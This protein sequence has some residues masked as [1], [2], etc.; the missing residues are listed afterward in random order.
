MARIAI[1]GTGAWGTALANVLLSNKH[2]VAMWGVDQTQIND[3]KKQVNTQYYGNTKLVS[4][5]K[6]VTKK[7]EDIINFKPEYVV[8]AVPS[9][10]IS[11]TLE[12]FANKF[13]NTPI[14]INVAKG[15]DLK[16]KNTWSLSISKIIKNNSLGLV[17]LIGPSFAT[18]VF[19]K[20]ITVVNTVSDKIELAKKVGALFN[21]KFF[22]CVEI[23]DVKG[24]ETISAIKNI[25]A[26]GS[27]ILYAQHNSINT[28][29]AILAQIAKEVQSI[30]KIMG[31]EPS[32]LYQFCGIGDIFLTCTDSKSRNFSFGL[33]IGKFGFKT[34]KNFLKNNTVEGYWAAK[35][36]YQIITSHGIKAPILTH[37]YKIL[38]NNESETNFVQNI[39][40]EINK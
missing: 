2:H 27:G 3:L 24:A 22:K 40:N 35:V 33:E 4:P 13:E 30:V 17:T 1:L 10:H 36:V 26:I 14:Y 25:M 12:M 11:S 16:T 19:N 21:T 8:I 29:A 28:R 6:L 5:L 18:E 31:G 23:T 15:F 34:V 20:N 39:I 7:S 38:Y 32:T 9:I 37:I